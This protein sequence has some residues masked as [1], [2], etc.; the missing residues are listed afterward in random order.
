MKNSVSL[1]AVAVSAALTAGCASTPKDTTPLRETAVLTS[2]YSLAS[3]ILPDSRGTQNVYTRP[4]RRRIDYTLKFDNWFMNSMF[5]GSDTSHIMRLDNNLLWVLDNDDET[6]KE[7]PLTGCGASMWE[8]MK[9]KMDSGEMQAD[10]SSADDYDPSAG[11]SCELTPLKPTFKVTPKATGRVVNGFT[12]D[13]YVASW[14]IGV[15]DQHGNVD[16]NLFTLDFWMVD[17]DS[18]MQRSWQINGQF[19]QRYLA[20]VAGDNPMARYL[21]EDVYKVI[22]GIAGDTD[23]KLLSS[24]S[25]IVQKL[26]AIEGY[27]VSL[28]FEWYVESNTCPEERRMQ[29]EAGQEEEPAGFGGGMGSISSIAGSLLQEQASQRAADYFKPDPNEPVLKYIYDVTS[30]EVSQQRDSRFNV[31]ADYDLTDRR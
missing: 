13:Q 24:A 8:Q 15:K 26:N 21:S 3:N 16:K 28:K 1:L 30:I 7:C 12:A 14:E 23:K 22:S 27:P 2:K 11:G 10:D 31:P 25:P 5:G 20:K 9:A 29:A 19:Q 4:D 18:A 17:A 6:Y